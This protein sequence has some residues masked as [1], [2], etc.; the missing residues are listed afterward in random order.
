MI[1]AFQK[2]ENRTLLRSQWGRNIWSGRHQTPWEDCETPK[3]RGRKQ[4]LP[5]V[6][7]E[8]DYENGSVAN[9]SCFRLSLEKTGL[10]KTLPHRHYFSSLLWLCWLSACWRDPTSCPC[11]LGLQMPPMPIQ[12]LQRCWNLNSDQNSCSRNFV[13]C[14]K[15]DNIYHYFG[16]PRIPCVC[17]EASWVT[18][19]LTW[20]SAPSLTLCPFFFTSHLFSF[21]SFGLIHF[22]FIFHYITSI[23]CRFVHRRV[24][25]LRVMEPPEI[26]VSSCESPSMGARNQT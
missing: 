25:A 21:L 26:V 9:W 12:L 11:L 4:V 20:G 19:Q 22:L 10:S 7:Y 24:G 6:E 14:T 3:S 5:E 18:S 13:T 8:L 2:Y 23:T 16:P 17:P 15:A 1:R